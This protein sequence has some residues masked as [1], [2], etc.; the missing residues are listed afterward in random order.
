[1]GSIN[2]YSDR[3]I[4][5][6]SDN[7]FIA[8][9]KELNSKSTYLQKAE[10]VYS[11][12]RKVKGYDKR[13]I[14]GKEY[15]FTIKPNSEEESLTRWEYF[16]EQR[17]LEYCE[18]WMKNNASGMDRVEDMTRTIEVLLNDIEDELKGN[19]Y[20]KL[21]YKYGIKKT[22]LDSL[23]LESSEVDSFMAEI[24]KGLGLYYAE[25]KLKRLQKDNSEEEIILDVKG[26]FN[27][28]YKLVLLEQLGFIKYI[29]SNFDVMYQ[30]GKVVKLLGELLGVDVSNGKN[31]SFKASVNYLIDKNEKQG[32]SNKKSRDK[33]NGF[34]QSIGMSPTINPILTTTS[35]KEKK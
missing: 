31:T 10:F 16:V 24:G 6:Y 8:L 5:D 22:G 15:I 13:Q 35:K 18:V 11:K 34:L 17:A 28:G 9:V 21:G 32:P 30:K 3:S 29:E 4:N 27:I 33:V 25:L 23:N 7:E 14:D 26:D 19:N 20:R 2:D 1:M 12:F